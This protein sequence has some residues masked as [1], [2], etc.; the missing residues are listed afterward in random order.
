MPTMMERRS[1]YETVKGKDV[2]ARKRYLAIVGICQ[3]VERILGRIV[4]IDGLTAAIV[5]PYVSIVFAHDFEK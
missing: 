4:V 1:S 2:R 5:R 3:I